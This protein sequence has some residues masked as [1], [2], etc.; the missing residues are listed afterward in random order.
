MSNDVTLCFVRSVGT[1]IDDNNIYELLFTENSDIFWGEGFEY[2][3]ASLVN[4]ITPN[5][6]SYSVTKSIKT[7]LK[8]CLASESC[9]YSMQDCIDGIVAIAY[10][11]I[12]TYDEFPDEGRLVLH[13]GESYD[14]IERKLGL[15]GIFLM[16]NLIEQGEE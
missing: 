5:E 12:S 1:D 11:D 8:L 6:G 13:Y 7:S 3:P 14:E 2:V 10:E 16:D 15:R 4:N 9:C